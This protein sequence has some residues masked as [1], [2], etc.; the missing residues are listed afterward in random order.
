M[1]A[2]IYLTV[3]MAMTSVSVVL[4][5]FILNLHFRRPSETVVPSWIRRWLLRGDNHGRRGLSFRSDT[6]YVDEFVVDDDSQ[7][8]RTVPLR[9]TIEN[10]AKELHDELNVR[11]QSSFKAANHNTADNNADSGSLKLPTDIEQNGI[12]TPHQQSRSNSPVQQQNL[13]YSPHRQSQERSFRTQHQC[14]KEAVKARR[15]HKSV[16]GRA[17]ERETY[18][19]QQ[20]AAGGPVTPRDVPSDEDN[21]NQ[22]ILEALKTIIRKYEREDIYE[23]MLYEWRKVAAVV[24]RFLFWVFLV[25]TIASTLLILVI[26]PF[27]KML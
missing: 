12:G 11:R 1:N 25:G 23:E 21:L 8:V 4:T 17:C 6:S 14:I 7:A 18:Y 20:P 26:A 3:V 10:L 2:G 5:V 24:D 9:L 19:G 22:D 16:T 27:T 13:S 15:S